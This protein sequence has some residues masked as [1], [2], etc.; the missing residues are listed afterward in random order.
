MI[1][2]NCSMQLVKNPWD[3]D[4]MVMPNLYGSIV[5]SIAAGLTGGPGITAGSYLGKNHKMFGQACRNSGIDIA[6][7]NAANPTAMLNSSINLLNSMHLYR[8][9][10]LIQSALTNV[11]EEGQFLTADIGGT[12]STTQFTKRVIQEIEFLDKRIA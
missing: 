12:A 10:D 11:Y 2:D 6:G 8:F 1:V 9:A 3:F 7:Q 5:T 4:V